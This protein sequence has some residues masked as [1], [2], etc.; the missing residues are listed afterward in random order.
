MKKELAQ[1]ELN[2]VSIEFDLMYQKYEGI[3]KEKKILESKG[4]EYTN[5]NKH[6]TSVDKE[7]ENSDEWEDFDNI[8]DKDSDVDF[9]E[10]KRIRSKKQ[11]RLIKIEKELI[12][13]QVSEH[14]S[15]VR[16]VVK[17]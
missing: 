8:S 15:L 11:N 1:E 14:R 16:T 5:M 6:N 4:K 7:N 12:S 17:G 2:S 3:L 10:I 9:E 13:L